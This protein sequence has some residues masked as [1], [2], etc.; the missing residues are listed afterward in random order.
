MFLDWI[1]SLIRFLVASDPSLFNRGE[2]VQ[3]EKVDAITVS[4]V[5]V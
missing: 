4:H 2:I 3:F 1:S 5:R